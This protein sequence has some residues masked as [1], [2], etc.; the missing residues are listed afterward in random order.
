MKVTIR[1]KQLLH[2]RS[3]IYLDFW[4]PIINPDTG[5]LQRREYLEI[6]LIDKPK[7][8]MDKYCNSETM[9]LAENLRARRQLDIQNRN[10]RFISNARKTG[11]FITYYYSISSVKQESKSDNWAMSYKY[12]VA[13]CGHDLKFNDLDVKFCEDFANYMLS[14][15]AIG[16]RKKRIGTN[17]AV[18]YYGKFRVVLEQAYKEKLIDENLYELTDRIKE[19]ETHRECFELEEFQLLART[20]SKNPLLKRA[21]L[22]SG[23]TGL[24]YSDIETLRWKEVRGSVGKYSIQ[25]HQE[26]T[27]AATSLPIS[28]EA[29]G[30]LG[31]RREPDDL[32]FEGMKYS[33]V[34]T[35]MVQWLAKAGID[36][37]VTFHGF[38]HTFATLQLELGTDIYTISK[39]LGHKSVKTTEIY[40]K[41]RDSSKRQAA[42]RITLGL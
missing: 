7:S 25:F 36:R 23:L 27:E 8:E 10:Y 21:A 39:M 22:F 42:G 4:P 15:P 16:R 6:Y 41:V 18:S 33:Q 20:E 24:R 26:K 30:L 19:A 17:T 31:E 35:F 2:G 1:K 5:K 12:L 13:F 14:G 40:T 9:E 37:D 29:Y 3:S 32:V 34:K 11:S 38:R 28:E